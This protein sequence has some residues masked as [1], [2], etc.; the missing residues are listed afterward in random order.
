MKRL[1][2]LTVAATLV[3]SATG[4]EC[5]NWFRRGPACPTCGTGAPGVGAQTYGDPYLMPP[6]TL[7]P[8]G[9]TI[10]APPSYVPG[11]G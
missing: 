3:A 5:M 9:A 10:V 2:L 8:P 6:S 4:C 11:P 7:A 1:L